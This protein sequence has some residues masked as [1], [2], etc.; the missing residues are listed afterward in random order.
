MSIKHTATPW[1]V[2]ETSYEEGTNQL[3]VRSGSVTVCVLGHICQ[4][5]EADAALIVRAVNSHDALVATLE[6]IAGGLTNGQLARGET[7][8]SIARTALAKAK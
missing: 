6:L 2:D 1:L 7:V 4:A 3:I 8:G 5:A